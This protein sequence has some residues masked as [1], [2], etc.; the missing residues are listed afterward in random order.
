MKVLITGSEGMIGQ[1]LVQLLSKSK[2]EIIGIDLF[3]CDSDEYLFYYNRDIRNPSFIEEV[4]CAHNDITHI[5]HLAARTDLNGE[6]LKDYDTNTIGT[7]NICMLANRL[8][9]LK[10]I[11]ITSTQLVAD[12]SFG[13]VDH[14]LTNI[15]APNLY[16]KSKQHTETIARASLTKH[17][18]IVRPTTIWGPNHN[19][20]YLNFLKLLKL[21]LYFHPSPRSLH[22]S[23]GFVLNTV[24]QLE[25]LI[26]NSQTISIG[27]TFYLCDYKP[28]DLLEYIDGICARLLF[29]K[30]FKINYVFAKILALIGDLFGLLGIKV[31]YNSFRLKNIISCYTY[32]TKRLQE[33]CGEVPHDFEEALDIYCEWIKKKI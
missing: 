24:H 7:R 31:P 6:T 4:L 12:I 8:S 33:I 27:E 20:H 10:T 28:I 2:I 26:L 5:V 14:D 1:A 23:Y 15:I 11:C 22:K 9:Y 13:K 32:E 18:F 3:D 21:G 16:G 17:F 30:P 29:K 19:S 25:R